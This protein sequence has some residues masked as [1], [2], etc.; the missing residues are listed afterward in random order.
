MCKS[1]V[2]FP[3]NLKASMVMEQG[4]HFKAVVRTRLSKSGAFMWRKLF[5]GCV[6]VKC[7]AVFVGWQFP[8]RL[9]VAFFLKE[10]YFF[11]ILN[12]RPHNKNSLG[13]SI[14]VGFHASQSETWWGITA[15]LMLP[16][17]IFALSIQNPLD[18]NCIVS[19]FISL[20]AEGWKTE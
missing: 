6:L 17:S 8:K 20:S 1:G 18:L 7:N 19:I 16:L 13:R 11:P 5:S 4:D 12:T 10:K 15:V 14:E 3:E 2:S 9:N